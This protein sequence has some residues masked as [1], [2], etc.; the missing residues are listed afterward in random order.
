MVVLVFLTMTGMIVLDVISKWRSAKNFQEKMAKGGK[1]MHS[2]LLLFI[3]FLLWIF[4]STVFFSVNIYNKIHKISVWI[5]E[6]HCY[7][8]YLS[9]VQFLIFCAL[10]FSS[11]KWHSSRNLRPVLCAILHFNGA[12]FAIGTNGIWH[13][14][15]ISS[16]E[17]CDSQYI[18]I[19]LMDFFVIF[20]SCILIYC[21]L[22][23]EKLL[24][25]ASNVKGNKVD[26]QNN[27][28]LPL[29]TNNETILPGSNNNTP[30]KPKP[31]VKITT[32]SRA[33]L[34]PENHIA[35]IFGTGKKSASLSTTAYGFLIFE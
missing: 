9:A 11:H 4:R 10:F 33:T 26:V 27:V 17:S 32:V 23:I 21:V 20:Y 2:N 30:I 7:L 6:R 31:I 16:T 29:E 15:T 8:E 5:E 34:E 24:D 1:G 25:S 35:P 14:T 13:S 28:E 12:A 19:E 18:F 3:S 22:N